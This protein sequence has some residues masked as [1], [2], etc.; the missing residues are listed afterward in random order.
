[1]GLASIYALSGPNLAPPGLE[2][3][4]PRLNMFKYMDVRRLRWRA[5][6]KP[7]ATATG[8]L[9]SNDCVPGC[10]TGTN[11]RYPGARVVM[12]RIRPGLCGGP[13][14]QY[15]TRA[16]ITMPRAYRPGPR[17]YRIRLQAKCQ[18]DVLG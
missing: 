6:S 4:P 16:S 8:V 11:R 18:N 1:M 3:R 10:A 13:F 9:T 17:Q 12:S 7:V 14:A 5:W 15:Y 2:E